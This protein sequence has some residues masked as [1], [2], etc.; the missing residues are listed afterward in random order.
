MLR[1][2]TN[3]VYPRQLALLAFIAAF[4]FKVVMLPQYLSGVAG[5]QSA[6]AMAYIMAVEIAMF[7]IIYGVISRTSLLQS[8]M[9]APLKGLFVILLVASS[10]VKTGVLTAE[11]VSYVSTTMFDDGL[12]RLVIIALMV[13]LVFV[14]YKGANVIARTAQIVFWFIAASI[15]FNIL[16]A[17]FKGDL[18]NLLPMNFDASV[19]SACDRHIM[20]FGDFTPFLFLTVAKPARPQR[21]GLAI[22]MPL[23]FILTVGFIVVF[24]SVYGGG[25][26]LVSNAFNKIGIF[27]RIS[28]LL[29]TVDFPTVCS[30]IMMA[31]IKLSILLYAIIEGINYYVKRR[32]WVAV[33]CGLAI[34]LAIFFGIKNL[35]RAYK[36]ATS[37]VRYVVCA[38]EY[39]VPLGVYLSVRKW[40]ANALPF[41]AAG[42][43]EARI[44]KEAGECAER[45]V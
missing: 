7:F 13:T 38:I 22:I 32:G 36:F 10:S 33:I 34:G 17:Q 12:W 28:M 42:D 44:L 23:L 18:G 26:I 4:T 1:R 25:S 41:E 37:W 24:T 27:N 20:W 9:P 6:L 15:L 40:D 43:K 45:K 3:V 8:A 14:A 29:G 39:L 30:W 16:F 19:L 31:V 21:S 11:T 2:T 35:D 5:R